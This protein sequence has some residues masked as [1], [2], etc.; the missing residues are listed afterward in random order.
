MKKVKIL[1]I[2]LLVVN[3]SFFA[4]A[5]NIPESFADLAE[6]LMPSVVN[7]STTQTIVTNINPF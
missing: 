1:F 5:K 6:K 2:A 7:I 4:N 3:F